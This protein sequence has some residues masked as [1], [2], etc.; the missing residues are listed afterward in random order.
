[1][2][3]SNKFARAVFFANSQE[4]R[5][6]AS[7]EQA[8]IVAC[9]SFL[10]NCIV[11]WNYLYLSQLLTEQGKKDRA[12]LLQMIKESSIIS[13]RHINFHGEYDFT[14]TNQHSFKIVFDLEK[15]R[16]LKVA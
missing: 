16:K 2:E 15:I 14:A 6:G 13:W 4:F 1:M 10:Q 11:L 9:K 12:N 8:L 5:V 7:E 3:L